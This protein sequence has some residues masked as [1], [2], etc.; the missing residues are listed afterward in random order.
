M[1]SKLQMVING[2]YVRDRQMFDSWQYLKN[3]RFEFKDK[4]FAESYDNGK[5]AV[6][7]NPRWDN[8]PPALTGRPSRPSRSL[9][10]RADPAQSPIRPADG[11]P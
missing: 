2:M 11:Q 9:V 10:G 7:D 6:H 4:Y 3:A 5:P 1:L 8:P